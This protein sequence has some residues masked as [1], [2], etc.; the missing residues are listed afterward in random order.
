MEPPNSFRLA[1]FEKKNASTPDEPGFQ[2]LEK[3]LGT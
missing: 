1:R 3:N 2:N